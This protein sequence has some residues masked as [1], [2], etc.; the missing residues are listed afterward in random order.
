MKAAAA[1]IVAVA[2]SAWGAAQEAGGKA[3]PRAGRAPEGRTST[4][5][6]IYS[7]AT[8]GAIPA[9]LYRPVPGVTY[10][11]QAYGQ[12][13]GYALVRQEREVELPKGRGEVRFTDVAAL[14]EPTTVTFASLT[15]P[16]GTRVL[17]Q[18]FQF[19]LVGPDRLLQ[20][21]IDQ[22]IEVVQV[23]GDSPRVIRGE[24]LSTAGGLVL[25][26]EGGGV[27]VINGYSS[28]A[29]PALP[30]G[31]ITR[32]TLVWDVQSA[33]G[34]R[35][36]VRVAYQTSGIT[37][38]ADYNVVFTEGK[39]ANSGVLDVGAWVSILN[40]SGAGYPEARLK[41]IAGDVHRAPQA[42][43][44][45]RMRGVPAAPAVEEAAGFEEKSFFEYHLYTLG[46]PA[47][48]ADNS[49][50]QIELFDAARGVPCEKVMVYYGAEG[51]SGAFPSPMTDRDFMPQGNRKVDIYLRFKNTKENRMGMP[52]P[53]GRIRVSKQD[54]A[55][56][57]M[58]FIGED[59]IDH[60]PK[61]ET[62]L[63]RLGSAFDVV[64]ER[65][66]VDFRVD[67]R[68]RW[69]EETVEV[70]IRNRKTEPVTVIVKEN[71]YRWVNWEITKKTHEYEKIDARTVHFPVRVEKDGEAV[72]RYTVRYTW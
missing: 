7:T 31:L 12:V 54:P 43:P 28:I 72:V 27:R 2:G 30:K 20:K 5:I 25:R 42:A 34:G 63:I 22:P 39:D 69:M 57:S 6:T 49:T 50:K 11:P 67:Q 56:G 21:Y 23:E 8:P 60:T 1:V 32:P 17:E 15:D 44:M 68:A 53:S 16:A 45:G 24:L 65:K 70:S 66:Q 38:W 58:E 62:V 61:D 4:A 59:T 36:A 55:D 18:S 37:W 3:G 19:D 10:G 14:I 64:G 33:A 71:L 29:F 47:T 9:D 41:L 26:G 40:R 51:F 52:L 35:Q 48:I 13:P 46:R